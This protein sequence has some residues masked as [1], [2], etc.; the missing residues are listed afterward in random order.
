MTGA[1]ASLATLLLCG[2]AQ[3]QAPTQPGSP[4][5]AWRTI[6]DTTGRESGRV[7]IWAQDGRL[8]GR[9]SFILDPAKRHAVCVK[10]TDDR[11]DRPVL[12]MQII[13]GMR[14]DGAHWDGGEILDPET[15]QT[16][17]CSMRLSDGGRK[18]VVRGYVGLSLFGR[19][20][21]WIRED[22]PRLGNPLPR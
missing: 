12:G 17:R 4:V 1:A 20:Q 9:V 13:R 7:E 6:S 21:T 2:M 18:L 11:R 8:Y 10:C 3:A 16:Y 22:G 14:P 15:G 5:G 19:S